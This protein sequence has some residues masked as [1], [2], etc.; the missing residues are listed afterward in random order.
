MK[1]ILVPLSILGM[2]FSFVLAFL[3]MLFFTDVVRTPAELKGL[4]Q[5]G[6]D[7][8][9][10]GD[11]YLSKEDRLADVNRLIEEYKVITE[12]K[13][14]SAEATSDSLAVEE[15]RLAAQKDSVLQLQKQVGL[16]ADSVIAVQQEQN[17]KKLA[18]LY[19]KIKAASAAEILQ[20]E[21]ELGDT[22]VARLL[23][24]LP[25]GQSGKIMANLPPDFGARLT[26]IMQSL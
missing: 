3:A 2:F 18:T 19:S 22:T 5:G 20:Q 10:F 4:V 1:F 17:I 8:T 11:E 24:K 26:R 6:Q 25:P 7:S 14:K 13:L 23:K 12:E 15:T 21:T 9:A 16:V